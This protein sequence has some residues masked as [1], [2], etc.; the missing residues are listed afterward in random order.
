MFTIKTTFAIFELRPCAMEAAP[1]GLLPQ[2]GCGGGYICR[3]ASCPYQWM[4]LQTTSMQGCHLLANMLSVISCAGGSPSAAGPHGSQAHANRT[5]P[6]R[7]CLSVS[8]SPSLFHPPPTAP[9]HTPPPLYVSPTVRQPVLSPCSLIYFTLCPLIPPPP[10][11]LPPFP[12]SL[13]E[14]RGCVS[15]NCSCV[16]SLCVCACALTAPPRRSKFLS[17]LSVVPAP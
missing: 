15:A 10:S 17:Q 3:S 8:L 1:V 5:N 9:P 4:R 16:Q 2:T 7:T 11:P 12:P 14:D 13:P 6:S